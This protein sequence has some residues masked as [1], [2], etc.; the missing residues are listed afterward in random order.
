[1]GRALPVE[2]LVAVQHALGPVGGARGVHQAQQVFGASRHGRH[3]QR[4][5]GQVVHVVLRRS[6]DR[7]HGAAAACLRQEFVV[8]KQQA[9]PGVAD[10]VGHFFFRQ[11]VVDR[12]QH[13]ADMA[14]GEGNFKKRG[15]VLHQHGHDVARAHALLDQPTADA[16]DAL[17]K[18]RVGNTLLAIDQRRAVGRPLGVKTNE[19]RQVD[20][21]RRLAQ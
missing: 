6:V 5:A 14:G 12:Q 20:H 13:G 10:D 1:M 7:D 17:R 15:A 4:V 11:P 8:R 16:L 21:G 18:L 9:N 19:A 2:I 3:R